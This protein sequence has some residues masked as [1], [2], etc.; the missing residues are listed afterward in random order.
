M[1]LTLRN[2]NAVYLIIQSEVTVL[3]V[4]G[5]APNLGNTY[6]SHFMAPTEGRL[7]CPCLT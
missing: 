3:Y 2:N 1:S 6:K 7:Y 5:S 4:S